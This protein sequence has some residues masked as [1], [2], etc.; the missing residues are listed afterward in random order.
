LGIRI[1]VGII[2]VVIIVIWGGIVGVLK[3][4]VVIKSNL[5]IKFRYKSG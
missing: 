5:Y 3:V 1:R 2:A 4:E